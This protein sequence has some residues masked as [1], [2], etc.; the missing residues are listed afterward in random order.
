MASISRCTL[1]LLCAI[2]LMAGL[3]P[4]PAFAETGAEGVADGVPEPVS[5]TVDADAETSAEALSSLIRPFS[6]QSAGP[7][8]LKA[9]NEANWIDR[10]DLSG[11]ESVRDFY[12]A[13]VEAADNDGENDFLIADAYL[14]E[15]ATSS[16]STSRVGD[17][18][19]MSHSI[20]ALKGTYKNQEDFNDQFANAAS[21]LFAAVAAFDRD[22]PEVFWLGNGCRFT[23]WSVGATFFVGYEVSSDLRDA[24]Y[25]SE[26]DIRQGI[27]KRD[28]DAGKIL[29]AVAD[30]SNASGKTKYFNKWLTENNAYNT[31]LSN[32]KVNC[33]NAWECVSALSGKAGLEGPVCEGYA[34]AFKVLCD[35]SNIPCVLVD[36]N[37]KSSSTSAGEGHMWNY[38]QIENGKW[39][40]VDATWNDPN[41][42]NVAHSGHESENWFLVG[43]D[44]VIGG[45]KFLESHPVKNKMFNDSELSTGTIIYQAAFT[46]GPAL[47]KVKYDSTAASECTA[48]KHQFAG[49]VYNGDAT[50]FAD[51]TETAECLYCSQTD[52]RTAVGTRTNKHTNGATETTV[53]QLPTCTDAGVEMH[54]THCAVCDAV[55]STQEV[56]IPALGH[57][58]GAWSVEKSATCIEP[59]SEKRVCSRDSAHEER[60]AIAP[61]GHDVASLTP[62]GDATCETD[63]TKSGVCNR[64]GQTVDKVVDPG[65]ALGHDW[66]AWA[67]VKAPTCTEPGLK[68]QVCSRDE[69]HI[70]SQSVPALG[71][72]WGAWMTTRAATCTASGTQQRRCAHA[73]CS[74]VE[75]KT[76]P[77][78]GHAFG[79]YRSNGDAKVNVDGTETAT[80]AKCGAKTTR[81]AAGSALA[82]VKGRTVNAAGA[83]FAATSAST[84]AYAGP[85]S[86][87]A[88]SAT[89]PATV[90]ISGRA[91]KVTSIAPKA[92]AGNK[93]LKSVKIGANIKAIPAGAFK[94]CTALASVSF[95]ANVQTVGKQAFSGCKALKSV[96]LGSK[97]A[98]IGDSAFQNCAKLA[99]VTV[100][101]T[102]LKSIGKNAFAGCKKLKAI[103]LKTTKLKSVGKNALKSTAKKLVVKAPKSK[104]KAYQKLFKN[105]GSKTVVV[106]R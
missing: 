102:K 15:A 57:A 63:G 69:S 106:K 86:K 79:V 83:M 27:Q 62:N 26:A 16:N 47:A 41:P 29:A 44:T 54:V 93:R 58:W 76:L 1:S 101:S 46:N 81:T 99:K 45:M 13:L 80:C 91:Y 30:V 25:S 105:K 104:V 73:G 67:T 59:G 12:D 49:Y 90:T 51:G 74:Y 2:A 21:Y 94:G 71:H 50:C 66:G 55:V 6:L 96:T 61:L 52:Q 23:A 65:S 53:T 14:E 20:I 98:T 36:G 33:R 28:A 64:C 77:A 95:G 92:F 31:N 75:T 7:V 87:A 78:T 72:S 40:A 70:F 24:A 42:G 88:A 34:R 35:R 22:H 3:V 4:A 85:A 100:K 48:G 39:Y 68:Q 17:Y 97:V 43:S 10:L 38:V 8:P 60:R 37:A 56:E 11:Y 89:V 32:A 19:R 18:D 9:S 82:L 84:V 103:T 5:L